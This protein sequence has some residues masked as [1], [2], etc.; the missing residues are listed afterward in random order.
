MSRPAGSES[1]SMTFVISGLPYV[2]ENV[3]LT[4]QNGAHD[5]FLSLC[6]DVQPNV[7]WKLFIFLLR[8]LREVCGGGAAVSGVSCS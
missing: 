1:D 6:F 4:K 7:A 8:D 5:S 2:E 3:P